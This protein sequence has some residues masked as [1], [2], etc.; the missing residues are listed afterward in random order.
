MD[1]CDLRPGREYDNLYYS[2]LA[3]QQADWLV[4]INGTRLFTVLYRNKVLKVGR[5][6]TPTLAMLVDREGEIMRFRKEPFYT[7]NINLNGINAVSEKYKDRSQADILMRKA[8]DGEA[9]VKAITREQK[10]VNPPKLYDLTSLQRDANKLFG[11]TAKK[12]LEYT[13]SLYEKKLVTYPRTDSQFLSDDMEAT[14]KSVIAAIKRICLLSTPL[15]WI[16]FRMS[17]GF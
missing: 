16:L 9:S 10:S 2:A 17:E 14:A 3:R 7:V 5:V 15:M 6:Q 12:T 4:G 1:F 8:K 11:F 13:Q